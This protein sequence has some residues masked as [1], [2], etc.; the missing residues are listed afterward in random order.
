MLDPDPGNAKLELSESE[1]AELW[2]WAPVEANL[3]ARRRDWGGN[4]TLEE[5]ELGVQN[6]VTGL[7][8]QLEDEEEEEEEEGTA[9]GEGEEEEE[10]EMEIVGVHRKSGGGVGLEFDIA[11]VH[12]PHVAEPLV[13]LDEILRYMTTGRMP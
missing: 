13:P 12:H 7:R 10:D 8:R 4:F 11:A 1:L 2:E 3:E 5:R 6:V 9:E